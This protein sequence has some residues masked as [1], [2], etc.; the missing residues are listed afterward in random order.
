MD[1]NSGG[2]QQSSDRPKNAGWIP[3]ASKCSRTRT[4]CIA[5]LGR[6]GIGRELCVA[7]GVAARL[8]IKQFPMLGYALS[9]AGL[10]VLILALVSAIACESDPAGL[11]R[12]TVQR[13]GAVTTVIILV[14]A[15]ASEDIFNGQCPHP[16]RLRASPKSSR[17]QSSSR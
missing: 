5:K 11:T 2:S 4:S 10:M 12:T 17:R 3:P 8:P 16:I 9:V 14:I 15:I 6:M 7:R 13:W 1:E